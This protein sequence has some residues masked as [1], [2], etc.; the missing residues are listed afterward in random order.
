M[1]IVDISM[2]IRP[3]M[4]IYPGDR[5]IR[6]A[7]I[8][9][10]DRGD[11]YNLTELDLSAHSGTHLDAPCHFLQGGEEI[12]EIALEHFVGTC[13]VLDLRGTR[14]IGED[15]L[16]GRGI[17][18]GE[19]LLLK[20]DNS[21]YLEEAQF[22]EDHV[23]LHHSGARYLKESGIMLLGF[24]YVSIENYHAEK[25]LAHLELLAAGIPVLEGVD[26]TLVEEGSY[27][28][29]A[30]PLRLEGAEASPVRAILIVE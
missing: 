30:L 10:L 2:A 27:F 22:N 9:S 4:L 14:S 28:L 1:K 17:K 3:G 13:R 23:Y 15:E 26:L 19:R 7:R 24:D 21:S 29:I 18:K 25:P 20:T 11:P 5:E 12:D 8:M 16:K 6:I